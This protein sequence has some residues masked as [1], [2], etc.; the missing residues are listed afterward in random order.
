MSEDVLEAINKRYF[1]A[2]VGGRA[3]FFEDRLPLEAMDKN[4]CDILLKNVVIAKDDGKLTTAFP[5]WLQWGKRRFY[6]RGFILDPS[7]PGHT[8]DAFNLWQGYGVEPAAGDVE[9]FLRH[10]SA[11]VEPAAQEYLLNWIAWVVRNPANVAQVALVLRGDQGVGK[12]VI[13]QAL[14][15][16]F[17][18]HAQQ[19]TNGSH[20]VGKFNSHLRHCCFLFADEADF[21][22]REAEGTL[23][24]L[25]TETTLPIEGKGVDVQRAD[26]HVS[27]FMSTNEKWAVPAAVGQRR[28]VV[29]DVLNTH[30]DDAEYFNK[31]FAWLHGDGPPALL[32]YLLHEFELPPEWTPWSNRIVTKA[33]VEQQVASLRG[34][35]RLL[36]E[37]LYTAKAPR[38]IPTEWLVKEVERRWR[39]APP[40]NSMVVSHR[41]RD[42]TWLKDDNSRPRGYRPGDLA[43]ARAEFPIQVDWPPATDW[44][45]VDICD[46]S[47]A[48]E[49]PF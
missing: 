45:L 22:S 42:T 26:N 31:L 39:N 16:L 25:I 30:K 20:I 1:G 32:H 29:A 5:V 7:L 24:T 9:P 19:L 15:R 13:G 33:L 49:P 47:P 34:L 3:R 17:G 6:A 38:L 8:K 21:T 11:V 4:T 27:I 46:W 14:M 23:K 43:A 44:E 41:L 10:V 2:I 37:F 28:F 12:G 36:F 48:Q 40:I 18:E 35:D